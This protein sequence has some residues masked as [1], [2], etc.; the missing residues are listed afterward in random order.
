M[1][2]IDRER[3]RE[4]IALTYFPDDEH[5]VQIFVAKWGQFPIKMLEMA[6]ENWLEISDPDYEPSDAMSL[7]ASEWDSNS[8]PVATKIFKAMIA[9]AGE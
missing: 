1:H 2:K 5:D 8:K 9:K 4:A 6:A 7:E 3:L